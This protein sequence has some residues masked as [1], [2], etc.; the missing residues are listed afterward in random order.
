MTISPE[1]SVMSV[2]RMTS[3]SHLAQLWGR[4]TCERSTRIESILACCDSLFWGWGVGMK[5]LRTHQ[6]CKTRIA[7]V[8]QISNTGKEHKRTY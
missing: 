3:V 2:S 5:P 4:G 1:P 7:T 8:V 6:M